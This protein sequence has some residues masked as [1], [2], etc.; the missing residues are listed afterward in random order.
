V[1]ATDSD[2]IAHYAFKVAPDA[3]LAEGGSG[4]LV[5]ELIRKRLG[6]WWPAL[7]PPKRGR[8]PRP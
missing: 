3:V 8:K 1:I 4:S 5:T 2:A 7:G 6:S